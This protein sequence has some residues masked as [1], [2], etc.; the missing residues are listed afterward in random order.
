[1][2]DPW[3]YS[4]VHAS[5]DRQNVSII[6]NSRFGIGDVTFL[7]V[8]YGKLEYVEDTVK[9]MSRSTLHLNGGGKLEGAA[10]GASR[11]CAGRDYWHRREKRPVAGRQRRGQIV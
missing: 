9:R 4:A 3:K 6:Q 5:A 10:W 8:A 1:M 7:A 11:V 2:G